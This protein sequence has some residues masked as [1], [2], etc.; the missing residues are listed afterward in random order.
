M[1]TSVSDE[2]YHFTATQDWFSG[3]KPTWTSLFPLVT[4][5]APR[6]LEIGSWEGRS[7]VFVLETLCAQA[8]SIVCIDHFDLMQTP[9][10][11]ERYQKVS[12]NLTVTGKPFRIL[13]DFSVPALFLL[14]TEEMESS[15]PGFDWIYID[16]SH[17]AD[18]TFLDG[19][20]AWRL[21]R[22]GAILIF[23]D[24]RWDREL[25]TS[26]HH[27][28][29]GI[30]GFLALHAGEYE[31]ISGSKEGQYQM[32]IRKTVEMKIGFLR[33]GGATG[34]LPRALGYGMNVAFTVDTS[35]ALPA[36][37][38]IESLLQSNA[39]RITIY[40]VDC[41]LS[42]DDKKKLQHSI[43]ARPD[44][45][46]VFRSLP[47]D[48]LAT[49]LGVVW[50]KLD[51][52]GVIPV[53]RV[54]YLDADI[55]VRGSL[56]ELWEVDLG[57]KLVAAAVDVGLPMGHTGLPKRDEPYFNAGVLLLDLTKI[58]QHAQDLRSL[59][60]SMRDAH[61]RDQDVL[62][63][64][65]RDWKQL[66]LRWNAQGLGTY[67]KNSSSE[68]D[69]LDLTE[70]DHPA[71]VHF[72]G[73]LHPGLGYVLNPWVQPYTAKPWGY[74]GAPGNPYTEEWW[75]TV[76]RTAWKGWR[77]SEGYRKACDEAQARVVE[78]GLQDL[79]EKVCKAKL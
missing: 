14:L 66:S 39:G 41:G 5:P 67:A 31:T 16:G 74:A 46:I 3:N 27:P 51:L 45:T 63:T 12:H 79:N 61:F 36:A 69:R 20:L 49:S 75:A 68:R 33:K 7:A 24:Y 48:S 60:R 23:D 64:H 13:D 59:A 58:R 2:K 26:R 42:E 44:T 38:A 76:E 37:V 28:K 25:D 57:D 19:E 6:V 40:I 73:P 71:I 34:D 35:Y 29:R 70:Q 43:R 15:T 65:F 4:S 54:L 21:A 17:E 32:I 22:D 56:A 55:L 77:S 78:L 72:T 53:E 30:D 50:A 47:E 10:G 62:N 11:R 18:D 8:G 1:T 9:L 52:I